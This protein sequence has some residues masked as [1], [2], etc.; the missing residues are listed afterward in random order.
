MFF[1][2]EDWMFNT[3]GYKLDHRRQYPSGTQYVLSNLTAR[4]TRLNVPW[5]VWFGLQ[6]LCKEF[7]TTLAYKTFFY[8]RKE[9][10]LY[11]YEKFLDS[12]IGET[13]GIPLDHISALHDLQYVPLEFRALPEGTKVPIK[14]PMMT[15]ENT[16]PD[17]GWMTN[18]FETATSFY[19]WKMIRN[20]TI[21]AQYRELLDRYASLTGGAREFV[22]YQGHDFSFRGMSSVRSM[23]SHLLFF[24]GT[25]SLPAIRYLEELYDGKNVGCSVPAT[26]H[27]VMCAG[28]QE[29]E[30]E[31][32]RR[33]LKLYPKGVLSVVSDTWDIWHVITNILPKLKDEIMARDGKLVIRPD[34]GDPASILCG[35]WLEKGPAQ[36]G[37]VRLLWEIFGGTDNSKGYKELDS[38]IGTI[39]GDS[40]TLERGNDI[41]SRL[42][43]M[44]F[45]ST[46]V[47][48]GIGSY[49]YEYG[50][51]D[52]LGLAIKS[53]W[54]QIDGK[55]H[56]L[57]KKPITDDGTKFS[58]KGRMVVVK[59]GNTYRMID[60]MSYD[61][62][63]EW[64]DTKDNQL[65]I[66]WRNGIFYRHTN[67]EQIRVRLKAA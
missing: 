60:G 27:S 25:D 38:H 15:T 62:W 46:N 52:D 14:V 50:T 57:F 33:L 2:Y 61:E 48:Y 22:D 19:L 43:Q 35:N 37:V 16:H 64:D 42:K 39:Y 6:G 44:G 9:N 30:L 36:K 5:A 10:V 3:D 23:A 32:F 34:S 24:K 51:R 59:E 55:E 49:T 40:I 31:T 47:V 4:G 12:Y 67:L 8:K 58:A 66:Q 56:Q 65:K 1:E 41:S 7:F 17:F 53:T 45:A 28:G 11:D 21:A 63:K 29:D 18:Y 26:E 54:A 20:A 13:H